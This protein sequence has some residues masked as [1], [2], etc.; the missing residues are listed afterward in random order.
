M[1]LPHLV[2]NTYKSYRPEAGKVFFVHVPKTA[3]TSF[4][5]ALIEN[6]GIPALDYYGR[7]DGNSQRGSGPKP[8]DNLW[9]LVCGHLNVYHGPH[10]THSVVSTFR[11]PRARLLSGFRQRT[12]SLYT[13]DGPPRSNREMRNA[14]LKAKKLER[15]FSGFLL[16]MLES[17]GS[18]FPL[19]LAFFADPAS[20]RFQNP[21]APDFL[22]QVSRRQLTR[23]LTTSLMN[24]PDDDLEAVAKSASDKID[25]ASWSDTT[26]MVRLLRDVTKAD[27]L[28]GQFT[29]SNDRTNL[30]APPNVYLSKED[31]RRI[32]LWSRP[33]RVF[34]RQLASEGKLPAI[35]EETMDEQFRKTAA[36]LGFIFPD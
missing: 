13:W 23:G 15:D 35:S 32:E 7:T 2:A 25:W 31:L 17:T 1:Q 8:F 33:D 14:R 27:A 16:G 21:V 18:A 20:R 9:P 4:R 10:T 6:M 3:G 26:S 36:R 19:Q 24:L 29:R 28:V 34:L 22:E 30:A 5:L 11:E 12:R